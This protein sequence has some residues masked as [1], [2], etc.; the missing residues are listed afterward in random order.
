MSRRRRP[1]RAVILNARGIAGMREVGRFAAWLLDQVETMIRP[2]LSTDEIDRFVASETTKRGGRSAPLGYR[3]GSGPPF[4]RSCCTS[5]NQVVCHGIPSERQVLVDGDIVNVDVTPVIDGYYGDSSR[6]FL[7]GTPDP[8]ARRLVADTY[9][10]MR[11]GIAVIKPGGHVGDIGHA[12]QTFAEARGHSVVRAYAGHGVGRVFHG[13]PTISHFGRAGTGE[14]FV[15]GMTFTVEP[16]INIGD[17][18]CV[19]L[20]DHWTVVTADGSLSAQFEHTVTVTEDGVEVLTL[21]E[22]AV[23]DLAVR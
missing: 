18:R 19:T 14:A 8:E 17:W 3:G 6:T 7:V 21:S 1:E 20:S 13:P 4:P 10:A 22:G 23:L 16:M 2:G 5:V 9:E 15:P 12:I 11:R